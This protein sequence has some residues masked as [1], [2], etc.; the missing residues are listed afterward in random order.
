[1][2]DFDSL[3]DFESPYVSDTVFVRCSNFAS[4]FVSQKYFGFAID[5]YFVNDFDFVSQS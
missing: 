4:V 2:T 1:V 5:S 3:S